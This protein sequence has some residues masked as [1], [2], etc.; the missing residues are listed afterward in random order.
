MPSSSPLTALKNQLESQVKGFGV[1]GCSDCNGMGILYDPLVGGHKGGFRLCQCV[2]KQT[3]CDGNPPYDYYDTQK[4]AIVGCPTKP[5]RL[6]LTRIQHLT[7]NSGIPERYRG[8]LIDSIDVSGR[9]SMNVLIA[10]DHAVHTIYSAFQSQGP[11]RGL[12][13]YGPTGAGKTLLSCVILNELIRLYQMDAHYA[14]ISRDIIGKLRDTFNPHSE[15][16]GEGRRIEQKLGKHQ[17]LVI[18]DFGVHRDSPWVNS[19]LY[20]LIDT[21]YENNLLTILTSN[22]PMDSWKDISDGRVLSRLR[23][24]CLEIHMDAEDYRLKDSRSLK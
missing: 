23:E 14:K 15:A 17:A 12:Y 11:V 22:E 9:S 16:Y 3:K 21:R 13:L 8:R 4:N 18:D 19:V 6:A 7:R 20:D 24:M 10:L 1:T 5:A 2:E